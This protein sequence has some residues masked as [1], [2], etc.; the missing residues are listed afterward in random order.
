MS[1][2]LQEVPKSA[3][4]D[5]CGPQAY[6]RGQAYHK[7]NRVLGVMV[8]LESDGYRLKGLVAGSDK[9]PYQVT[10]DVYPEDDVTETS[11]DGYCSCPIEHDCKHAVALSLA[12][13]DTIDNLNTK[14]SER[15]QGLPPN[16]LSWLNALTDATREESP[17]P[18]Q[19]RPVYV[20]DEERHSFGLIAHIWMTRPRKNGKGFIK[21]QAA[22]PEEV[23]RAAEY[24]EGPRF[25]DALDLEIGQLLSGLSDPYYYGLRHQQ[26]QI[27]GKSGAMALE[28]M[29]KT[30]RCFWKD[31]EGDPITWGEARTFDITWQQQDDAHQLTITPKA[32]ILPTEP[33]LYWDKAHCQIGPA[34][35][36]AQYTQK[37]LC[38]LQVAPRVPIEHAEAFSDHF[39]NKNIPI[40]L[41][42][43][44]KIEATEI[45]ASP[46]GYLTLGRTNHGQSHAHCVWFQ[47]RYGEHK[48]ALLKRQNPELITTEKTRYRVYRDLPAE[49]ALTD[50]LTQ[51][52][53][54][55]LSAEDPCTLCLVVPGDDLSDSASRW[56]AFLTEGIPA[57][58]AE[59][60]VIDQDDSFRMLFFEG[61]WSAQ[62]GS[63]LEGD[64]T[65]DWFDVRFDL[66]LDNNQKLP[67]APLI[68]PLLGKDLDTLPAQ[69]VLPLGND[70]YT[71]ISTE[72]LK[73]YLETL[74][75]LFQRTSAEH[76]KVKLSRF[77]LATL[78]DLGDQ[79]MGA[80]QLKSIAQRLKDFTGIEPV[81][82]PKGLNATLRPYQQQ[83]LNWL[84]FLRKYNFN[85][86]LADDMGLGKTLQAIA[87]ILTEKEQGRLKE[88]ALIV[89]PTSLM[90]NW[91]NEV[92]KFAPQLKVLIQHGTERHTQYESL[93]SA[94]LVLTTYAL[95]HRDIEQLQAHHFHLL[96]LDE[97]QAIKNAKAKMAQAV[98]Q[99]PASHRLCLTGT[100]MENHLGE[101]W[102]LF[103]FLMPGFLAT[104]KHFKSFYRT[105][106]E[107]QADQKRLS[108]LQKRVSPFILRRNKSEVAKELPEKTEI[109][110]LI[111]M[112]PAQSKLYESIRV[113][114]DK[115]VR[116]AIEHKG[117]AKSHI[118]VLDAL[119]KLRQT[120]CD[121][122]LLKMHQ[123]K[124]V[125]HSA[126]MEGLLALLDQ[127]LS[128]KRRV[129]I[130]S[131]FTSML[132]LIESALKAKG[133]TLTKLTGKT[134][135][136]DAVVEAF[137]SGK[138]DVFLISLK[139][140]GT[141]LNLVEADTVIIY[142]PWWNPAAENQAIDR[143]HRIGQDKP[144]FVYRLIVEN[145][146]EEKILNLQTHKK[147]L[148][149]G[150]YD[151]ESAF[152]NNGLDAETIQS[153][154]APMTD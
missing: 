134:R 146:V 32:L 57:L 73:P 102:S 99:I 131:Q 133:I 14:I 54:E 106:I 8:K 132:T 154:F 153:L 140:G 12:F 137:R 58:E 50:R 56:Y 91:R 141:G 66:T 104:E 46:T 38:L 149:D 75:E 138:A 5:A 48:I 6:S 53:F 24:T 148:A 121:P 2:I 128:E 33:P 62:A 95:A 123:A 69:V 112:E 72:R 81:A 94:D 77:D 120:C 118:T 39:A 84:Q 55:T 1:S 4:I 44:V 40:P 151:G 111:A 49:S 42:T 119:L 125:K 65:H 11:I 78:D 90:G 37:Q 114:M 136:R 116:D 122:R 144:V 15:R 147:A 88:P 126:K 34:H 108:N 7:Q 43:P 20:L 117:L 87:H 150:I 129:L 143:A 21:G 127:L 28:S 79:L 92:S 60:W 115:Q 22:T 41:D 139:A 13:N 23:I 51:M 135:N 85:G 103:D 101:L 68:A 113:T 36:P 107:K 35:L 61:D 109:Q 17:D 130:F 70:Q 26:I 74:T 67:L 52:G 96:I 82:P 30:A 110:H 10:V 27:T 29:I 145:T 18:Q 80:E 89:A 63:L 124:S 47:I 3:L 16:L 71:H 19:N 25:A 83:G 59:G 64:T 105:P 86:I 97:A 98:R 142:D 31:K 152:V 93:M 45:R 76:D 9:K 100:P